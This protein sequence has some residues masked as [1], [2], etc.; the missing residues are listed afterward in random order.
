MKAADF[1]ARPMQPT[2]RFQARAVR[3][4][5]PGTYRGTVDLVVAVDPDAGSA[6]ATTL[7]AS[8][9]GWERAARA[10]R[11]HVVPA[12]HVGIITDQVAL[13]AERLRECF[14]PSSDR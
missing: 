4:Y 13:L 1:A 14:V 2:L 11:V 10:V 12:S 8:R 9:R 7:S 5:I 6:N 3:A